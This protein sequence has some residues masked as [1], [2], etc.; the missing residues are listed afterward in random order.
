MNNTRKRSSMMVRLVAVLAVTM[1]FTMCFVGGTFAKY[2]SSGTGTDSAKVAKWDIR[3]NGANITVSDNFTFDLF[4][5]VNDTTDNNA[6][7]D[8]APNG[9]TIIAPGTT[10][11]FTINLQNLSE[12]NAKYSNEYTVTS[13]V[14]SI[15]VQYSLDGYNW[16]TEISTLNRTNCT[17]GLGTEAEVTIYWKWDFYTGDAADAY[18]TLLGTMAAAGET[19]PVIYV[20]AKVTATQVD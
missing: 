8:M 5:T 17:I 19:V 16:T 13:N 20:S 12:V 10:G 7:T 9:G 2:T 6:E 14:I 1:M 15:P 3:V 4:N 18:D 11:K